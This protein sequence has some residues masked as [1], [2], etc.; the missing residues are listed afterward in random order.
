MHAIYEK[1]VATSR[2]SFCWKHRIC[3]RFP[4]PYHYHPEFELIQIR[5]GYGDRVV[6]ETVSQFGPGDLIFLAPNVPHKWQVAANCPKAE[7][8]YIQFLPDFMGDNFFRTPEMR[9]VLKLMDTARSGVIFSDSVRKEMARRLLRFTK[10]SDSDRLL[11]LLAV[12]LRLSQDV[13]ARPLSKLIGRVR[14]NRC[15]EEKI[16][17]I[18]RCLHNNL[19]TSLSLPAV[20]SSMQLSVSTFNRLLKRTTGKCFTQVVNELRIAQVCRLLAE[21][22][23]TVAEAALGSGYETLSHF[24]SQFRRIMQMSPRQY[25]RS[26]K[27]ALVPQAS[28]ASCQ[29]KANSQRVGLLEKRSSAGRSRRAAQA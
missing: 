8:I 1:V 17:R 11:E 15:D 20:A 2:Q 16:S 28:A 24:N 3:R 14:L 5:Q 19:A 23:R 7:A 12:L 22:D 13:D 27:S 6:G 29:A 21:T 9:S 4:R 25:R 18:F 10:L 26:L